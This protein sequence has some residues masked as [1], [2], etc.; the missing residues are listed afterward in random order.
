MTIRTRKARSLIAVVATLAVTL[1]GAVSLAA[2]TPLGAGPT[3]TIPAG[4]AEPTPTPT[5]T[6]DPLAG[7]ES[8]IGVG[9]DGILST[10][11]LAGA[12]PAG[13]TAIDAGEADM[14]SSPTISLTYT[15]RSLGGLACEWNNGEPGQIPPGWSNPA[16]VGV[17]VLVLPNATS[18]WDRFESIYASSGAVGSYCA[19]TSVPLYCSTNQIVGT[20]WVEVTVIG[21]A[22]EAAG[23]ALGTEALGVI[24]AAGPGAPAWSPPTD[25]LAL[26]AECPGV[27]TDAAVQS[28]LGLSDPVA[29]STGG[30]GWSLG[31]GARENWGGP[32]CYWSFVGADA[33]VGSLS[34]LPG[35]AWAWN[36]ASAFL[37]FPSPPASASLP[38][39]AP[40][41]EAWLR[42]ASADE[43]CVLDLVIGRNWV[44]V[45]VWRDAGPSVDKRAG[46]LAIGSEIV[47]SLTP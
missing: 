23:T 41:D 28:A 46:A 35:G 7:P 13:V 40:G 14:G 27:V 32:H 44:E 8:V 15:V 39:L 42:C 11:S 26:P 25:T 21:A 1:V 20:S 45:Y 16:Y 29:A 33:G 9:C 24:G 2:C 36:E 38:G 34:T 18:Q 30:G 31:A 12:F 17:I 43:Y 3:P 4:P 47:A 5:P 10:S 22:S 19:A 37:T 6:V